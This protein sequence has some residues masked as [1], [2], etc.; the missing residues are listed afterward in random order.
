MNRC[1]SIEH[2]NLLEGSWGCCSCQTLNGFHREACKHCGHERCFYPSTVIENT[3]PLGQAL[4]LDVPAVV[5]E[6]PNVN[7]KLLN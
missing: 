2:P 5:I 7:K 3:V 4:D 1:S 6:S